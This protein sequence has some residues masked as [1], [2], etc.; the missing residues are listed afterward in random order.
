M[1]KLYIIS[2]ERSGDIHA[3]NLVRA[4]HQLDSTIQFRG[5]GGTY[6][7]EAGVDL[8]VNYSEV[9]LM[10]FLEVVLGFRKSTQVL[11]DSEG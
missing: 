10:G 5:M 11:E 3:S 9:A 6:S 7:Q 4:M 8:A 1:R 2:G